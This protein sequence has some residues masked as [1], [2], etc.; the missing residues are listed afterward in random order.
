MSSQ[1][2]RIGTR[3]SPLALVQAEFVKKSLLKAHKGFDRS[4]E[5]VPIKTKGDSLLNSTFAE[6][7]GKG[8]FTKEIEESL[9]AGDIHMAVHSMK[10]MPPKCPPGLEV[11]CLLPREDPRDAFVS[12]HF[13][14]LEDLPE[15]ALLGTA[16][17]RRQAQA[18][19]V[20]PDLEITLLRGNVNTRLEKIKKGVADA[21]IMAYAGLKRLKMEESARHVFST[22]D[23]LPAPS[24]G[25][26]GVEIREDDEE[27]RKLLEPINHPPTEVCYHTERTF[28]DVMEG[29]CRVPIGGYALLLDDSTIKFQ[30]LIARPDGRLLLRH[31]EEAP[32][33]QW[34]TLGES[35]GRVLKEHISYGQST[36]HAS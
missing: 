8:V 28:L 11:P 13:N 33:N 7:G 1:P 21:T 27:I 17:V 9:L 23:F 10:D 24:Q 30:G 2:I 14:N 36:H 15:G 25:I 26:I 34:E 12:F 6:L 4:I 3:G 19:H 29:N 16:S 22:D 18:L 32:L 5:I 35:V 20:R 31:E